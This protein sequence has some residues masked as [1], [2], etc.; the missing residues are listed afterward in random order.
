MQPRILTALAACAVALA[1]PPAAQ[2][3]PA[4][5]GTI[6]GKV[7]RLPKAAGRSTVVRV[8]KLET[9]TVARSVTVRRARYRIKVRPGTYLLAA[10]SAALRG[11]TR[12]GTTRLLR[13][14]KGKVVGRDV[15]LGTKRGSRAGRPRAA[16]AA[17]DSDRFILGVDPKITVTGLEGYDEGLDIDELVIYPIFKHKP[18]SDG[19]DFSVVEIR[20]RAEIIEEIERSNSPFFDKRTAV[21]RGHLLDAKQMIRGSG[22]VANGRLTLQ[23]KVVDVASGQ[24]I[25]AAAVEGSIDGTGFFDLIDQAT[26]DL[27]RDLCSGKVDVTFAGSGTYARDE[28]PEEPNEHHIDATYSWSITYRD[29]K[30]DAPAGVLTFASIAEAHGYWTDDGRF[31]EP[32][33]GSFHCAGPAIGFNGEFAT[34]RIERT[35]AGY[36]L[37][38]MPF[39]LI[40]ENSAKTACQGLSSPPYESFFLSGSEAANQASV[41]FDPAGLEEAPLALRV[42]PKAALPPYCTRTYG[43]VYDPCKETLSWSGK[44]TISRAG[45]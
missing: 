42:G 26:G 15:S 43:D 25:A 14:R 40:Q 3:K 28:G 16:A 7:A 19:S 31:G 13:V 17:R 29:V 6:A 5:H 30:L 27:M 39:F 32:G 4:R 38:A 35:A 44:V 2:A 37:V 36:R 21:P 24:V 8:V 41:E 9:G 1:L 34:A 18:C 23:L 22:S 10:R 11:K 45:G 20:R 33:P 12:S